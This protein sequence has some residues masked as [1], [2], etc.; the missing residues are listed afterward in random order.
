MRVQPLGTATTAAPPAIAVGRGGAGSAR[1]GAGRGVSEGVATARPNSAAAATNGTAATSGSRRGTDGRDREAAGI[2]LTARRWCRTSR[3]CRTTAP[4]W[5]RRR[6]PASGSRRARA[7]RWAWAGTLDAGVGVLAG[8]ARGATTRAGRRGGGALRGSRSAGSCAV[9]DRASVTLPTLAAG[10]G[11]GAA[12][13]VR[14]LAL[15]GA[16]ASPSDPGD[17]LQGDRQREGQRDQHERDGEPQTAGH[18]TGRFLSG[19]RQRSI[20]SGARPLRIR[21]R[22]YLPIRS[23]A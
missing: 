20:R 15:A 10:V 23:V 14:L 2:A 19:I 3:C 12:S 5:P 18:L 16:L 22:T 9:L 13:A 8:V 6:E 11:A 17:G 7:R 21:S 1:A 4:G